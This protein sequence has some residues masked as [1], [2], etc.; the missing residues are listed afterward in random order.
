MTA[1]GYQVEMKEIYNR[2]GIKY[3]ILMFFYMKGY[4]IT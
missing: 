4:D 3:T 2:N 1:I